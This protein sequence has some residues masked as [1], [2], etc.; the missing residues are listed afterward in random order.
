MVIWLI[1]VAIVVL[2]WG[3]I[4]RN[5]VALGAGVLIGLPIAWVLSRLITPYLT[6]MEHIPVWLPP[7]PF[8]IVA[9]TLLVMGAITWSR[10]D[11]LPPPKHRDEESHHH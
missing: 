8:A 9:I 11:R 10:A 7:L 2:L 4:W 3:M 5:N 6:G 1:G